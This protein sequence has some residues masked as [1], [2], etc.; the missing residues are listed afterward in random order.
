MPVSRCP[1]SA[2]Y[3]CIQ[4]AAKINKKDIKTLTRE[5]LV[6]W[7][8]AHDIQPYRAGQILKWIYA[9]QADSFDSNDGPGQRHP[10]APVAIFYH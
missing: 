2:V 10:P 8:A 1:P 6:D 7:L 5:Q 9:R 4:Y 3:V